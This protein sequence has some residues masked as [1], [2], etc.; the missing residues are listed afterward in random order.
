MKSAA[1]TGRAT[2]GTSLIVARFT[3]IFP[4]WEKLLLIVLL[5]AGARAWL[6]FRTPWMPGINGAYCL[7]QARALLER[8]SL[9]LPDLPLLFHLHAGLARFL[10][11]VSGRSQDDCIVLA[12]KL[13]DALLPA[14]AAVP[15]FFLVRKWSERL[16]RGVLV[17]LVAAAISVGAA[18]LLGM[19]GDFQKNALALVWFA[20]LIAALHAWI[21]RPD[22]RCGS[23]LL[24]CLALLGVTHVGVLGSALVLLAAVAMMALLLR[25]SDWR[26]LLRGGGHGRVLLVWVAGS[27]LVLAVAVG[28]VAWKFDPARVQRLVGAVL[29]PTSFAASDLMLAPP[30]GGFFLLMRWLIF[31][32]FALATLPAL[33]L[34]WR[35]RQHLSLADAAVPAG[36][37]LTALTL[38]GPWFGMDKSMRFQLIALI[39]AILDASFALLHIDRTWLRATLALT[40]ALFMIGP[41]AL[42]LS[43]GGKPILS[44]AA[45]QEVASL[46]PKISNPDRTLISA[47]HGVEWWTAWLLRTR[48]AQGSALRAEDWS[49][50]DSVL[51]LE[52]K[53]GMQMPGKGPRPSFG[54]KRGSLGMPGLPGG[55]MPPGF[56]PGAPG[57]FPPAGKLPPLM[58]A[59]IPPDAEI[60]HDG[61]HL[62]LARVK[63]PPAALIRP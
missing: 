61:F 35:R 51:F 62:K 41:T 2:D 29:H 31:G 54:G 42:L 27:A 19:V 33:F 32:V 9:G 1:A 8:G 10:V 12:V 22:W 36:C 52:I 43:Q 47:Q 14:L 45:L 50:F 23:V 3:T 13:C 48:I 59:P 6:L 39:P 37:A 34:V 4:H 15:V 18:P 56:P 16:G 11:L 5:A 38:S 49:H 21:E 57:S 40:A 7:V 58:G 28:V 60:V 25:W 26:Q 30:G 53:S 20:A 55:M 17:P 24:G 44:E 63:Q 46:A